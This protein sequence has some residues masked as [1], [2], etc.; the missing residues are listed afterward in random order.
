[1]LLLL[2][3]LLTDVFQGFEIHTLQYAPR[4]C[5]GFKISWQYHAKQAR[6]WK[7]LVR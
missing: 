2:D 5:L 6:L 3:L 7:R 4:I 1:M